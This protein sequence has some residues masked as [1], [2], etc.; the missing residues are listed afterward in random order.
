MYMVTFQARFLATIASNLEGRVL[1]NIYVDS[2]VT[3]RDW[4]L[5]Q[6]ATPQWEGAPSII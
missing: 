3:A 5:G 1:A 6:L 2:R 4:C